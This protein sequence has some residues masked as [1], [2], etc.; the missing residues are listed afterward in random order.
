M[1]GCVF[2]SILFGRNEVVCVVVDGLCVVCV[3]FV[4][5]YWL[6]L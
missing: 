6:Y 4:G 1:V 3:E 2:D 5:C